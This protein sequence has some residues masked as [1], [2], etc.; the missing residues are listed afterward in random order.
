MGRLLTRRMLFSYSLGYHKRGLAF[1]G[2]LPPPRFSFLSE[3]HFVSDIQRQWCKVSSQRLYF[4]CLYTHQLWHTVISQFPEVLRLLYTSFMQGLSGS[5]L[6]SSVLIC[7]E[8]SELII[9]TNE[10]FNLKGFLYVYEEQYLIFVIFIRIKKTQT[11][12]SL[13]AFFLS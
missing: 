8:F 9:S 5:V 3:S 10:N 1:T 2:F 12:V 13:G 4:S 6:L 7:V 11:T